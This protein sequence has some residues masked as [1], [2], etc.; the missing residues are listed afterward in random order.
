MISK[1]EWPSMPGLK[2]VTLVLVAIL[3]SS[4][5]FASDGTIDLA[6]AQVLIPSRNHDGKIISTDLLLHDIE[7]NCPD[8]ARIWFPKVPGNTVVITCQVR[9]GHSLSTL[10]QFDPNSNRQ[11]AYMI[12]QW[13]NSEEKT[14]TH[15]PDT[16][17]KFV[18]LMLQI[19]ARRQGK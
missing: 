19:K 4:L 1:F 10:F 18:D 13:V 2:R 12:G 9:P 8:P 6:D 14:M 11:L 7:D 3:F 5:A 17:L 15:D 16:L